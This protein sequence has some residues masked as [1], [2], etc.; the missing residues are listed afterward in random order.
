M[1]V[2]DVLE[3]QTDSAVY[4]WTQTALI[5][6]NL[7]RFTVSAVNGRGESNLSDSVEIYAA[8]IPS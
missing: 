4:E 3:G 8:T 5:T 1:Y 2:D 6:G 7:Y